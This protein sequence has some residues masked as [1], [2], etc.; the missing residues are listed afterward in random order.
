[1]VELTLV[2]ADGSTLVCSQERD[3]ETFRAARVGLGSLGV[4]AEVTLRC[5]PAFTLRGLDAPA[6]LAQ[7]LE[8]FEELACGNDHFEFFV[9]PHADVA[10][11]RTNN[12]TR[13]RRAR[14]AGSRRT[15][16]TCC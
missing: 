2:L 16:T 3:P 15:R 11:T 8:R 10:L 6:P 14:A 7:T 9:F 13:R 1:M 5:V 12:R 4:I